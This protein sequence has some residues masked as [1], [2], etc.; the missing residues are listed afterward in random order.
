MDFCSNSQ[1]LW[2]TTLPG[3]SWMHGDCRPHS[4]KTTVANCWR[5][6][7]PQSND[8]LLDGLFVRLAFP[9]EATATGAINPF[10]DIQLL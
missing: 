1:P 3:A 6:Y 10:A 4:D 2:T 9:D 8:V 5:R 7:A